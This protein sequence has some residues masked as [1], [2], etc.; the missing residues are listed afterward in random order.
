MLVKNVSMSRIKLGKIKTVFKGNIFTIK[1]QPITLAGGKKIRYEFCE[2]PAS[3]STLAF[4]DVGELLLIKERRVGYKYNTWFL[5]GG[6]VNTGGETPKR[7]AIRELREETGYTAK[8]I[9]LVQKKSPAST[10]LWDI[11][12]FAAKNLVQ[13]PLPKD[14]GENIEAIFIPFKKAV[15]M[16]LDGTIENEFI[17]YNI[18]RFNEILKQKKFHW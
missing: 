5:P 3:V 13:A 8:T 1:Q 4:N 6:R 18:I 10:L 15:T 9:K 2:R 16:A 11:Y 12:L 17:A 14:V 7:A